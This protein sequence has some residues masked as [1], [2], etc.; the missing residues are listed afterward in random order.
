MPGGR[1]PGEMVLKTSLIKI[2][3]GPAV[4]GLHIAF[5]EFT[6]FSRRR[7]PRWNPP[8]GGGRRAA[9]NWAGTDKLG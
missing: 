9:F 4:A 6:V 7:L 3:P 1:P 2:P 8:K 5:Y